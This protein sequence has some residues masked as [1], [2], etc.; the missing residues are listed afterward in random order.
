M[1]LS[2]SDSRSARH[3]PSSRRGKEGCSQSRY[4][5]C[6]PV[7][8]LKR[9]PAACGRRSTARANSV[10]VGTSACSLPNAPGASPS[11]SG[12]V[13]MP[14]KLSGAGKSARVACALAANVRTDMSAIKAMALSF[15]FIPFF[16]PSA[17]DRQSSP[18]HQCSRCPCTWR[19]LGMGK[20]AASG[21]GRSEQCRFCTW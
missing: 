8:R 15:I 12:N 11:H 4:S 6:W 1:P 16:I 2:A 20:V 9:F 10:M 7:G 21:P 19:H 5:D 18:H 13:A 3:P 14:R 17:P